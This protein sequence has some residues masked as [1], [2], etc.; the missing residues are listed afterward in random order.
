MSLL[1]YFLDPRIFNI[2]FFWVDRVVVNKVIKFSSFIYEINRI[3]IYLREVALVTPVRRILCKLSF[4]FIFVP[5]SLRLICEYT[6]VTPC[7]E[8]PW[9]WSLVKRFVQIISLLSKYF[10]NLPWVLKP[11]ECNSNKTRNTKCFLLN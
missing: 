8:R 5:C 9:T 1:L 10:S 11:R 2:I 4:S 3:K 6:K 7:L